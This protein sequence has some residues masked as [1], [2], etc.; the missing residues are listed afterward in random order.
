[1][2]TLWGVAKLTIRAAIG[3]SVP[4]RPSSAD[5][6]WHGCSCQVSGRAKTQLFVSGIR[7]FAGCGMRTA[8]FLLRALEFHFVL[9]RGRLDSLPGS[10]TLRLSDIFHLVETRGGV[11][12]VRGV[13]QGFF[14]LLG[15]CVLGRGYSIASCLIQFCHA[16][17][18]CLLGRGRSSR[19]WRGM[20]VIRGG[21]C[22]RDGPVLHKELRR[23]IDDRHAPAV[24]RQ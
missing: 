18:P 9:F 17:P 10:A 3:K 11:A 16:F 12:D 22:R 14:A 24:P 2:V 15:K 7:G 19:G 13:F 1:M 23:P 20:S 6:L 4:Q 8:K 21:G 5:H